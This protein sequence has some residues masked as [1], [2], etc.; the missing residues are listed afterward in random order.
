MLSVGAASRAATNKNAFEQT[1]KLLVGSMMKSMYHRQEIQLMYGQAGLGI[2]ESISGSTIKIEDHEWAPAIWNGSEKAKIDI[3]SSAGALRGTAAIS[4][5]SQSAKEI[6]VDTLPVGTSA[7]D[8]IYWHG[9]KDKE[10]I[11]LHAIGTKSGTLFGIDNTLYDLFR[12]NTLDV[13]TDFSGSEAVLSFKK[14][15]EAVAVAM[16]K[17][18]GEEE[19]TVLVNPKSWNALLTEQ[20]AKRMYDSSY[21]SSEVENGSR[22]IKFYGMNGTIEIVASTF[23]KEGYAYAMCKKDFMRVGSSDVTFDPPGYEGEFF[24]LMENANGY[25]LRSY[26]DIALF[27]SRPACIVVL[28]YIK[29]PA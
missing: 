25:E 4:G 6:T 21:S 22:T 29:S 11:G 17:G 26:S 23:C 8:V 18:L 14:V 13:G 9:A 15:E 27:C 19:V 7:T 12:G 1:T 10:F 3:Y 16:E 20:A 28:R 2:V 5:I 24:K